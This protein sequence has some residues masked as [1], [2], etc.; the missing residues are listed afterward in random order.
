MSTFRPKPRSLGAPGHARRGRADG[1]ELDILDGQIQT[2]RTV[3][4][5]DKLGHVGPVADAWAAL[6]DET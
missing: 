3:N 4:N 2:I 6:R 1:R 5:P